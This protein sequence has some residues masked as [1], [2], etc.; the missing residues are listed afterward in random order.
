MGNG[1]NTFAIAQEK[2]GVFKVI[3]VIKNCFKITNPKKKAN[4]K[5]ECFHLAVGNGSPF[6][7][8]N[9]ETKWCHFKVTSIT[10][11]NTKFWSGN[12]DTSCSYSNRCG[13]ESNLLF[14]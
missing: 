14:F 6:W 4:C 11:Q 9:K 2:G 8:Y 5:E 13:S 3:K 10:K 12:T 7:T 1:K